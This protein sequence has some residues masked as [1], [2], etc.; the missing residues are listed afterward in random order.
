MPALP[1]CRIVFKRLHV[2]F[3]SNLMGGFSEPARVQLECM[4]VQVA[5]CW[6]CLW[7]VTILRVLG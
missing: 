3:C 5:G 1:T 2:Y 4:H 6:C 7:Y